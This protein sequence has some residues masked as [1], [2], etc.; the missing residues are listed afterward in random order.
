ML[1]ILHFAE[2]R[3]PQTL[4]F[5]TQ[6]LFPCDVDGGGGE[7]LDDTSCTNDQFQGPLLLLQSSNEAARAIAKALV[8]NREGYKCW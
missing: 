1:F 2:L 5:D 7:R 4:I 3:G 8:N 6:L